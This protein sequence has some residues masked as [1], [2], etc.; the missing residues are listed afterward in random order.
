MIDHTGRKVGVIQK[1]KAQQMAKDV[2]L[3]LVE[4]NPNA[5]PPVCKIMDYGKY[6][7]ERSKKEHQAA[8]KQH[9]VK[10]KELRLS[11]KIGDHDLD[12]KIRNA[13]EMLIAGD[14]VEFMLRFKGR[15]IAHREMGRELMM[16]VRSKLEDVAVVESDI[17]LMGKVIRMMLVPD[18]RQ[19]ERIRQERLKERREEESQRKSKRSRRQEKL[20]RRLEEENSERLEAADTSKDENS[21]KTDS[22]NE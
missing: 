4:L 2:E 6:K 13:R 18:K 1:F 10:V 5:K 9:Q 12:V 15:E 19:I 3:D 16:K 22:D 21:E 7:Y 17:K 11:V 8:K 14:R 20:S